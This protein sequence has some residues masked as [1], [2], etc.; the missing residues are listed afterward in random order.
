[1]VPD[2]LVNKFNFSKVEVLD[3]LIHKVK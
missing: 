1:M 3:Y 2:N